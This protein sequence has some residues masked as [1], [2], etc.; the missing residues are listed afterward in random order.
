MATPIARLD[1]LPDGRA[2]VNPGAFLDAVAMVV[3]RTPS[4]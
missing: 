3:L 4:S 1:Q 2:Y